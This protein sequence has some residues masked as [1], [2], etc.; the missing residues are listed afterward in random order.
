MSLL[1]LWDIWVTNDHDYVPFVVIIIWPFSYWWLITGFLTRITRQVAQVTPEQ[2][3][4]PVHISLSSVVARS[5]GFYIVLS[6]PCVSVCLFSLGRCIFSSSIYGFWLP[7]WCL[8]AVL[9]MSYVVGFFV[10]IV[11]FVNIAENV[12][13]HCLIFPF[14]A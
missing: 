13:H 6:H 3:I 14:I 7:S 8:Q 4:P 1:I 2:L 9:L 11:R 5:V 12:D 10:V